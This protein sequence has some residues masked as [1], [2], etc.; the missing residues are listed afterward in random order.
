MMANRKLSARQVAKRDRILAAALKIFSEAGYSA[1]SMDAIALE[2]EVSKPTLYMYFG[3]KEQL[4]ESMMVTQRDVMLEP[5]EHPSGDMVRD[6]LDFAWHYADVVMSPEFLSLAR[7]IVG[8]AQRFPEIGRAY[9]KA[10]PDRLLNGIIDYLEK[11][12]SAGH[13][14]FEDGELAAQD[15]WALILSAPRTKA[16]HIPDDIP[17]RDEIRRYLENGLGVFLRAYSTHVARDLGQLAD[18]IAAMKGGKRARRTD[19]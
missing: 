1:A 3:S 4:F 10:G 17:G 9:Q 15:F 2:A 12:K 13:L 5:F 19:R 6:L 14:A 11:Q 18:A 16:L 8:E 7:L